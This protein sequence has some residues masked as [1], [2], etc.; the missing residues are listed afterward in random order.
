MR[1]CAES[2]LRAVIT[3]IDGAG[4]ST[5][6]GII[7]KQMGKEYILVKPGPSRPVYTIVGGKKQYHYHRIIGL[8]DRLHGFADKTKNPGFI[9]AVN[10]INV[11]LNGRVIEPSLVQ[12][13]QP[14]LVLGA[15]DFYIDPAVY[16]VVYQ[17]YLASKPM[18]ERIDFLKTVIGA[19][20][21]DIV[22]FLTLSPEEAI[23]RIKRR[24]AK[25]RI[26]P[27]AGERE[28]WRHL[29]ENPETLT[30]LQT[31]YYDALRA[32][33][34]RSPVKIYEINTSGIPQIRVAD[35]IAT[36]IREYIQNI[37]L[38]GSNGSWTK[39]ERDSEKAAGLKNPTIVYRSF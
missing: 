29:H 16:S 23:E 39:I 24:I 31:E 35:F 8:I 19:P 2:P 38:R 22:F 9:G 33:Q 21:R 7:A 11:Y 14:E 25:E 30:R 1:Y 28:K 12:R 17:P 13:F 32:I 34:S 6:A 10:T 27:G 20:F 4:K 15:R 36:I 3:G 5:T 26:T 18:G 37:T